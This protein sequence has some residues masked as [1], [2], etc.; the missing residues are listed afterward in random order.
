MMTDSD[1]K[2]PYE[3][4]L[5]AY[6]RTQRQLA[7]LSQ[8]QLATMTNVSNAYLSQIERGLHQ[9]SVKVLR[10]IADALN[11]S[12]E[13]L[14]AR[15]GMASPEG[16]QEQEQAQDSSVTESAI[17]ADSQL[18]EEEKQILVSIYRKFSTRTQD[19]A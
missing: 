4:L 17:L 19:D 15:A 10:S 18:S 7:A 5:G 13:A 9:P 16:E 3:D 2:T 6:I 8:R 12:G 14:F 1:S 11:L